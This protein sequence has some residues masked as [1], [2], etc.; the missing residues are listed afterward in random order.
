MLLS[1]FYVALVRLLGLVALRSHSESDKDLEILVLRHELAILRR[2]VRRP[3]YRASDRAFLAAV[4]RLFSR[5]RWGAFLMRPETLLRWHRD[6]V[7]RKWTR[8]HGEGCTYPI[9]PLTRFSQVGAGSR[10]GRD[11]PNGGDE[12]P[13][14]PAPFKG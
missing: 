5:E 6:L 13:P 12:S 11:P 3:V 2:Q 14:R 1:L 7:R 4:S 9:R 10:V 8:P